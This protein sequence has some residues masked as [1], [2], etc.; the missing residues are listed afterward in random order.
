MEF[1]AI[2]ANIKTKQ[3]STYKSYLNQR[4]VVL[5]ELK[6]VVEVDEIFLSRSGVIIT[7]NTFDE[8]RNDTF[9]ILGGVKKDNTNVF[10]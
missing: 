10:L 1:D 4:P 7:T 9:L 2:I 8:I 3:I 5:S 6:S